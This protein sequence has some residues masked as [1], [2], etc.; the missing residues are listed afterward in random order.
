MRKL[1]AFIMA[2]VMLVAVTGCNKKSLEELNSSE[3][4]TSG[5]EAEVSFEELKPEEGASLVF[6]ATDKEFG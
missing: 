3:N 5:T 1:V 6:W 2:G 4:Q